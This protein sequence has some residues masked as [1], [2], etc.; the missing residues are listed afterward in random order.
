MLEDAKLTPTLK[1]RAPRQLCSRGDTLLTR[2]ARL[3]NMAAANN[4]WVGSDLEWPTEKQIYPLVACHCGHDK[5][6]T[7]FLK[8]AF[9]QR[10]N[11]PVTGHSRPHANVKCLD[12]LAKH[13]ADLGR[14]LAREYP[15]A[16]CASGAT[17]RLSS[18]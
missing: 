10:R 3:G 16:E 12:V 5:L 13:G 14:G 15:G 9:I 2:A 8:Q 7:F 6:V 4:Y 17:W 11:P 1:E 18:I